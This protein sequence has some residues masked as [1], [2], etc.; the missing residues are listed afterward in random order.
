MDKNRVEG[1]FEEAKGKVKETVGKATGDR[2][3]EGEGKGDQIAGKA[4]NAYGQAKDAAKD[5]TEQA[6]EA[7]KDAADKVKESVNK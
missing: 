2:K 4:Q 3:L 5:A 7:T 6:A 1:S